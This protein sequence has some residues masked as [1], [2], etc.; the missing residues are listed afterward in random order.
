MIPFEQRINSSHNLKILIFCLITNKTFLIGLLFK[1]VLSFSFASPFLSEL[2]I[3]FVKSAVSG[4]IFNAYADF[5]EIKS[6][7]FPYPPVMLYIL[8][9]PGFLAHLFNN[10]IFT[11]SA[12]DFFL[13]RIPF[14]IADIAI[15]I[16]LV[17]WIRSI[18]V[19]LKWY[20]LNP[21]VIYISYI[22]GQIDIIPTAFLCIA[23][24]YLFTDR[25]KLF[26]VFIALACATKFHVVITLPLFLVYLFKTKKLS[27]GS[28]VR[29]GV[30]FLLL[31]GFLNLPYLFQPEYL[32]MVYRN[33]EQIKALAASFQI[34]YNYKIILI[35][36]AYMI[37]LY[38]LIDFKFINKDILLIFLALSFGI[39]TFFIVPGQGWYMWNMPFFIYFMIRFDFQVKKLFFLL[40]LAYFIFFLVFPDSDI[41]KIAKFIYLMPDDALN[42]YHYLTVNSI[43]SELVV[44]LAFTFLQITLLLLCLTVLRQGVLKIK[45]Y[46]ISFQPYL[47]GI[48]GDSGTGKSTLSETLQDMFGSLNTL[49]VRGDD[50]HR[51]ERGHEKWNQFTHLNPKANWLHSDLSQLIELKSGKNVYR[52]S[53]DHHTGKFTK[54][55]IINSNKVIVYEGLHSFYLKEAG[56]VYDMKIFMKPSEELRRHWKIQRDVL[57]RG[58]SAEKVLESIEKRMV[59]SI[60]HI[61]NQEIEA[62][63]VFSMEKKV[64]QL[65]QNVNS[66]LLKVI[67]S[68]DIYFEY[69]LE[70]I[71]ANTSI[72]VSHDIDKSNQVI[73]LSGD[74]SRDLVELVV[75]RTG[76]DLE[77]M[78]GAI[79]VWRG[80]YLGLMQLFILYQIFTQF[81]RK[82]MLVNTTNSIL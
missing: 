51:W 82:G 16:I 9:V 63:I 52:R 20:W 65:T 71:K 1:L 3:P 7:A 19:V 44:Q 10:N 4:S 75:Y 24:N 74:I 81:K 76:L 37:I 80:G 69:L 46:K 2:F 29:G 79:P 18:E 14:F 33:S 8:S 25:M 38:V 54:P 47:I 68:N 11:P 40:N 15:L 42:I 6:N 30:F 67:C 43:N 64:D 13:F 61:H 48:C 77:E 31:V 28:L 23:L 50:M 53:Y 55:L 35:P 49:V 56:K 36:S 59:D 60:N 66:V 45:G 58:Y 5:F 32:K 17:K 22:H 12:I 34:F 21:V 57:I 72:K 78:T 26:V 62:D 41:P 27:I 39:F 73:T 70:I